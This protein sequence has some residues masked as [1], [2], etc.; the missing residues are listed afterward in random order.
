MPSMPAFRANGS[1]VSEQVGGFWIKTTTPLF[2]ESSVRFCLHSSSWKTHLFLFEEDLPES[3]VTLPAWGMLVDGVC[4]E[5]GVSDLIPAE[6]ESGLLPTCL[7]SDGKGGAKAPDRRKCGRLRNEWKHV[8]AREFGLTYPHP[9]HS[10]IR[11]GWPI[12]WTDL[13]PL[14]TARFQQ[15]LQQHSV[16]CPPYE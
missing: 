10:E 4:W 1:V 15:W 13:H 7:A 6:I 9:T 5:L 8:V 14:E 12:G 2:S 11:L 16:F 3:S